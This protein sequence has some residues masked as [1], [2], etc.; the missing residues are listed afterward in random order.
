[1]SDSPPPRTSELPVSTSG[2]TAA[3]VAELCADTAGALLRERFLQAHTVYT[4]G[5]GNIVTE[6]DLAAEQ[7][8]REILEREYPDHDF[9]GEETATTE[10]SGSWLWV[11]DPL[12]GT[13]NYA[14]GIPHF[15]FNLALCL[16]EQPVLALTHDPIRDERFFAVRG[17]GAFLNGQPIRAS[18][19]ARVRDSLLSLDLGYEDQRGK[20]ALELMAEIFPAM[21]GLRISGSAALGLAYAAAGRFD[22]YVHHFLYPW[23]VAAG[24]LL[25]REAGGAVT[26][27]DGG[28]ASIRSEGVIAG[29]PGV[30]ADFLSLT[31]GRP[32]RA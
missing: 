10:A 14:S 15:C 6:T 7:A 17:G 30:H 28:P 21:D 11:I 27:R 12:D 32:W 20:R 3:Q 13:R 18:E 2:R 16:A 26:D 31:A 29:G 9:L 8:V 1:M 23:D 24:I 25:V 22:L 4:K 19:K 5:R